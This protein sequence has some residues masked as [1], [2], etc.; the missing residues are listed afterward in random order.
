[1]DRPINL[2]ILLGVC[3]GLL[4]VSTP[5]QKA[6]VATPQSVL[7]HYDLG[8]PHPAST[9]LPGELREASGLAATSDGR[10]FC[11][12]DERGTV[13]Q[14]DP[15]MGAILRQLAIGEKDLRGDFEGI[16][17]AGSD[18]YLVTSDGIIY[19]LPGGGRGEHTE[20]RIFE[21]GLGA[22]WDIEGLCYDPDTESLLL[23]CK[24]NPSKKKFRHVYSF[25]LRTHALDKSPRFVIDRKA[26]EREHGI[27]DF[28]PTSIERHPQS[29][30]FL[31]LS[32]SDPAVIELSASGKLIA[33]ARLKRSVHAQPEGLTIGPDLTIYICNEGKDN[34]TLVRYPYKP[35]GE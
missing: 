7:R 26:L 32:S 20:A 35:G 11:H 10:L 14:I 4:V 9:P 27:R 19:L 24:E 17:I 22:G 15:S 30:T 31:L 2:G 5:F 8:D 3:F 28:Q 21:T 33:T 23:A 18:V 1:M 13:F 6:G 25:S 12:N 16:A 29:G 34:G